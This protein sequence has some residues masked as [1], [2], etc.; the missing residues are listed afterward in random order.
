MRH[1]LASLVL[2]LFL[3]PS[4]AFGETMDDL[5]E[6][7]G[8]YYKKFTDVPFTGKVTGTTQGS[9]KN[10]KKVG[11]WVE[12]WSN[13]QLRMKGNYKDGERD[14]SWVR[15]YEDGQLGWKGTYRDWKREGP[16]VFYEQNGVL[17]EVFSGNYKNDVKVSE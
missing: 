15:Y 1:A 7:D 10:G 9:L 12:Y 5:V 2:A 3:F 17:V 16:W 14:G 11:P 13:G 6:R 4:I 8:I